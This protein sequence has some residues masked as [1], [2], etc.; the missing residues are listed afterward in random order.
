MT[1]FQPKERY[2]VVCESKM[3]SQF[4]AAYKCWACNSPVIHEK[5]NM[6]E[7]IA[8][9]MKTPPPKEKWAKDAVLTCTEIMGLLYARRSQDWIKPLV[10]RLVEEIQNDQP[11]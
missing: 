2:C 5:I 3:S 10:D 9:V 8:S 7:F 6:E 4:D 1:V 11:T